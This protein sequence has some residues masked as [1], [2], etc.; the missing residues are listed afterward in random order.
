MEAKVY[1]LLKSESFHL[2]AVTIGILVNYNA[3]N[4][5]AMMASQLSFANARDLTTA[6]ADKLVVERGAEIAE[7]Q[8]VPRTHI[9]LSWL[10]QKEPVT[11]PIAGATKISHL[12][13]AARALSIKLHLRK[14]NF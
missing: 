10:L 9:A 12:E 7:K 2:I 6:N 3:L 4:Q 14:V 1:F 5:D 11:P 8:G 13:D